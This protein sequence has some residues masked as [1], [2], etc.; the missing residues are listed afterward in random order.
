[1][2][3]ERRGTLK[4]KA[5]AVVKKGARKLIAKLEV[6]LRRES[7]SRRAYVVF[8][9]IKEI[10]SKVNTLQKEA[11]SIVSEAHRLKEMGQL[12]KEHGEMSALR[13]RARFNELIIGVE[14]ALAELK[15]LILFSQKTKLA[16]Y[17][18]IFGDRIETALLSNVQELEAA[19]LMLAKMERENEAFLNR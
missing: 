1:M 7:F 13:I 6:K 15:K 17:Y 18:S 2:A 12:K 11:Q 14:S 9:K 8:Q 16:G 10:R 19:K 4:R 5:K 3:I